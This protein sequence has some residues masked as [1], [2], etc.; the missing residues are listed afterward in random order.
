MQVNSTASAGMSMLN[1]ANKQPAA[2]LE[3][4]MRTIQETSGPGA[5][6]QPAQPVAPVPSADHRGSVI[7]VMA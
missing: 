6:Q 2:A 3:L 7:D 4:L 5:L 1:T